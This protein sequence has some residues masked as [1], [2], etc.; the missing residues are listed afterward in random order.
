VPVTYRHFPGQFQGFFT[1]GK[2]LPQANVA[3]SEIAAWLKALAEPS[4][5]RISQFERLK[6]SEIAVVGI[7]PGPPA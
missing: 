7:R 1:T 5:K 6:F 3:A 4:G 2:L